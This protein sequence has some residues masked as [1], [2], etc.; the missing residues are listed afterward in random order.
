MMH[1]RVEGVQFYTVVHFSLLPWNG[2]AS[3]QSQSPMFEVRNS[4][5]DFCKEE[6]VETQL[7]E[8]LLS[9]TSAQTFD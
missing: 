7:I 1:G 4:V 5:F 3:L 8:H 2:R 6:E 9:V